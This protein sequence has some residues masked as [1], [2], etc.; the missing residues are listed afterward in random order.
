MG[1]LEP[2]P[3]CIYILFTYIF[4]TDR[5]HRITLGVWGWGADAFLVFGDRQHGQEMQWEAAC[6]LFFPQYTHKSPSLK[7]A[8]VFCQEK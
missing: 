5:N 1:S 4:I 3:S 2:V 7:P 6:L 8:S